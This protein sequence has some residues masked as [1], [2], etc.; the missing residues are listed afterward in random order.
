MLG[1]IKKYAYEMESAKIQFNFWDE[2]EVFQNAAVFGPVE[3]QR[4]EKEHE[5]QHWREVH[6]KYRRF[7][8]LAVLNALKAGATREE[9][10]AAMEVGEEKAREEEE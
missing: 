8:G 4:L 3:F 9:I 5:C 10:L 6:E 1:N 7:L 2:K